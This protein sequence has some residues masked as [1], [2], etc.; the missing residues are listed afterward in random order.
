MAVNKNKKTAYF[1]F[2]YSSTKVGLGKI[3]KALKRATQNV[4]S[5]IDLFYS[6]K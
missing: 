6:S 5:K 3:N 1:N 2:I 4:P